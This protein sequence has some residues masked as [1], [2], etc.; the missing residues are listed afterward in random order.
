MEVCRMRNTPILTFINKLDRDG[1]APME[2]LKMTENLKK[3]LTP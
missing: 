3:C 2:I 1:M